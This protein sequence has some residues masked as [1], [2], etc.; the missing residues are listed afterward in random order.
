[1]EAKEREAELQQKVRQAKAAEALERQRE[2][3]ARQEREELPL[4][5]QAKSQLVIELPQS[6][7]EANT[8]DNN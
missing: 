5:E 7:D 3:T 1:M 6:V 8:S 4:W 2:E